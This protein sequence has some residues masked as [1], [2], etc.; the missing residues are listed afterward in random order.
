MLD[1]LHVNLAIDVKNLVEYTKGY[2]DE[3]GPSMYF[4]PD[5]ATGAV[6]QKYTI[7]DLDGKVQQIDPTDNTND[8]EGFAKRNVLLVTNAVNNV[9]FH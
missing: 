1:N 6:S 4:Y 7:L 9:Q 5:T 2:N 3:I 8:N